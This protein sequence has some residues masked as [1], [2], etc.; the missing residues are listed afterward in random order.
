M[1]REIVA[2]RRQL[3][4]QQAL[5]GRS[6][7]QP[8][9]NTAQD[10]TAVY[11]QTTMQSQLEH[12]NGSHEAVASLLDLRSGYDGSTGLKRSPSN[13]LALAKKIEDVSVLP[14]RVRELFNL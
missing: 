14:D 8:A 2:L 11:N 5:L 12:W 4:D 3:A 1:E 6:D 9:P 10:M 7:A 13:Q